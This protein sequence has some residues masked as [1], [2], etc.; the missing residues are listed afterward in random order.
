MYV[1]GEHFSMYVCGEHFSMYVCMAALPTL[2]A[3]IILSYQIG[4]PCIAVL[5]LC[6]QD[7]A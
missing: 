7:R 2:E 3:G 5:Y 4:S 6:S 1:C